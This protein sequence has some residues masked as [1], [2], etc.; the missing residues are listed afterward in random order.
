MHHLGR[1]KAVE[2]RRGGVAVGADVLGIDQILDFQFGQMFML[3]N[4]IQP[5]AGLAEHGADLGLAFFE[6]LQ[7][8]LAMVEDDAA[9]RVVNAVVDV[10]ARSAVAHG[11]ADD[12]GDAG[13]GAGDEEPS[14]LGENLDVGGKQPVNLGVDDAGQFG[15]WP[16]VFVVGRGKTAADVEDLDFV[17]ARPWTRA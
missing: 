4:H 9:E 3:R 2:P 13:C 5:V 6:R 12:A 14:R 10:V 16:D 7:V 15:E 17:T 11:L 8:I 1:R